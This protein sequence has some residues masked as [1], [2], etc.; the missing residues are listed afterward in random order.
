MGRILACDYGRA[1]IGIA[2]SDER[3]ILATPLCFISCKGKPEDVIRVLV[4]KVRPFSPF[5]L[6]VIG[7]PLMLDG[8]KG[9][10]AREAEAFGHALAKEYSL[11]CLFWDERLSSRQAERFMKEGLLS[12][13]ERAQRSDA[14]CAALILQ[15]Y[16]DSLPKSSF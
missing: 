14:L 8:T 11:P 12:R 6:L 3:K 7:L 2:Y 9:E 10:M 5:E 13:K 16:L 1:R 15:N 4:E